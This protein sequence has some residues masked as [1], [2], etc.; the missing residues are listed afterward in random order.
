MVGGGCNDFGKAPVQDQRFAKLSE[1]DIVRL[2]VPV[3]DVVIVSEGQRI[4]DVDEVSEQP[5][6]HQMAIR[7]LGRHFVIRGDGVF[8]RF[9]SNQLHCV[10]GGSVGL[11][12]EFVNW[13]NSGV[14]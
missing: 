4:A 8:K 12:S 1:H 2:K 13:H 9:A 5:R 10:E 7:S 14:L 11:K 6:K 3:K